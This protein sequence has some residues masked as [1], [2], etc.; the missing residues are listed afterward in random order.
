M[1]MP[2]YGAVRRQSR[3]VRAPAP[4]VYAAALSMVNHRAPGAYVLLTRRPGQEIVLGGTHPFRAVRLGGRVRTSVDEWCSYQRP[5][6]S[7]VAISLRVEPVDY[8]TARI[9]AETRVHTRGLLAS[10]FFRAGWALLRPVGSLRRRGL[11]RAA[12]TA[13]ER[14]AG[15]FRLT[16]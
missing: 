15:L 1:V 8:Q 12:Q 9:S 4:A 2:V 3:I 5:G 14:A 13:A 11:L 10:I 7:R 6:A 16:P